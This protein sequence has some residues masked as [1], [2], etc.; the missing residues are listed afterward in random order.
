MQQ[1]IAIVGIHTDIGKTIASAVL[2]EALGA[3]YWKP[4]Q[5]GSL[6]CSDSMLVKSL[7]SNGTKRVHP[8]A[9]L[10]TEPQ[11]P[12]AAAKSDG[13]QIDHTHF[14]LPDTNKTLLIETAGGVLSPVSDH[15]TMADFIQYFNLP[16]LLISNNYLGSINHTLLSIEVLKKRGINILGVV[17]NGTEN[18]SSEEFIEA[19][20]GV[21]IIAR[22]PFF[23]NLNSANIKQCAAEI[24]SSFLE[25]LGYEGN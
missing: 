18:A 21:P 9:V 6:D 24:R 22:I 8:E 3:D 17:M 4:V 13:I 12:H 11:S 19:Y 7:L 10:L 5:A 16:A 20:T 25:K 15:A 2:A 23:E 1:K 14:L